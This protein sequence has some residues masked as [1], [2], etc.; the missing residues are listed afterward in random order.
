MPLQLR[1]DPASD[2]WTLTLLRLESLWRVSNELGDDILAAEVAKQMHEHDPNYAGT[3]CALAKSAQR[4]GE[5][6]MASGEYQ[7]AVRGWSAADSDFRELV[8]ARRQL[9]LL[10]KPSN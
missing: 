10:R 2:N 3:H 5:R 7:T 9:T 6:D 8:D 1:A 4:E